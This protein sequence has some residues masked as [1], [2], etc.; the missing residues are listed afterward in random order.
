MPR[1]SFARRVSPDS[2]ERGLKTRQLLIETAG[3]VFADKGYHAT[4]S[5]EIC[6]L[7]GVNTAAVNYY[8]GGIRPLY[9]EAVHEA[10]REVAFPPSAF[11][12]ILKLA[13]PL[14]QLKA[15]C[16]GIARRMLSPGERSW[17]IRLH[18][19]E[20]VTPI[21]TMKIMDED[22]MAPQIL[23]LRN[24]LARVLDCPLSHPDIG[25]AELAMMSPFVLL[26]TI[27][28]S[29]VETIAPSLEALEQ[30][31]EPMARALETFMLG[32]LQALIDERK[33]R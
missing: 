4:T 26:A 5:R 10:R 22:F 14:D 2:Q 12:A 16:G 19:R 27:E 29:V 7:A 8:F 18:T 25:R 23:W 13:D 32:G 21:V 28:R 3:Q 11:A 24:L 1:S 20:M 15:Y 9:E 6:D 17:Q 31:A 33:R 30:E